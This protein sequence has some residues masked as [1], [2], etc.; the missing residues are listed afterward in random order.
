VDLS[1]DGPEEKKEEKD[2]SKKSKKPA[3][4]VPKSKVKVR[5]RQGILPEPY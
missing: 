4:G 3:S 2:G 1:D 5:C